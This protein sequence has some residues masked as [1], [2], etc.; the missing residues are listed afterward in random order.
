[1]YLSIFSLAASLSL[2]LLSA[3]FSCILRPSH[4]HISR[5]VSH[6]LIWSVDTVSGLFL[7]CVSG[8][9]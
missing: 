8:I 1:V 7:L 5:S 2:L 6:T 9:D 3:F 4:C